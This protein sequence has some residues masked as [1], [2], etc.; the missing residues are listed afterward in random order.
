V[1]TR[2]LFYVKF[3]ST[4]SYLSD[5]ANSP[6]DKMVSDDELERCDLQRLWLGHDPV[7]CLNQA[8]QIGDPGDAYGPF[9]SCDCLRD[10]SKTL[11]S[12]AQ[13]LNLVKRS[14][15]LGNI[16]KS[17]TKLLRETISSFYAAKDL[18]YF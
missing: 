12:A 5:A 4:L 18:V 9:D 17:V 14:A 16:V 6:N 11:L 3:V 15:L 13:R 7:I 8:C 1:V 2:K 10:F